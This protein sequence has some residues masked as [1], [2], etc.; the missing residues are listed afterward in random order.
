MAKLRKRGGV[1]HYSFTVAGKRFRR[2]AKTADKAEAEECALAH[3]GRVRRAARYGEKAELTF[4]EA[5]LLYLKNKPSARFI[6]D[7]LEHFRTMK[8]SAITQPKVRDAARVLY[9]DASAA[10]W[11]R[12]VITPIRAVLNYAAEEGLCDHFR[13]KRF[14]EAGRKAR[15]AGDKAWLAAFQRQARKQGL[16]HISAMA[17]FMFETGARVG[18]SCALTWDDIDLKAGKA[19]LRTRK[20]GAGGAEIRER[21]AWLTSAMVADIA[22]M[23]DRHPRL[24]FGYASKSTVNKTW[25]VVVA[26]AK[27]APL[28]CHEAGRH[29]FATEMVVRNGVDVATA[30]ERGGWLSKRLMLDTYVHG[31]EGRE[32]IDAVFGK[33]NKG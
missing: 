12:Q 17:R 15:P 11:N 2:S 32:V 19:T 3:E 23:K 14:P 33:R 6:N 31:N 5:A 26:N 22:N 4:A 30:A 8:C 16:R 29:G 7:L 27:I 13:M 24:V 9:P 25:N 21:T 1:W 28:T 18:Q 10:T 20:T